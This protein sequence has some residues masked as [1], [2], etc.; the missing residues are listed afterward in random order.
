M[1]DTFTISLQQLN[2]TLGDLEDNRAVAE[3]AVRAA[4]K[5]D[6]VVFPEL[7]ITGYPPEDLVLKRAFTERAMAEVRALAKA[8]AD[9]PRDRHR[10]ALVGRDEADQ[11][12]RCPDR[13]RG[14]SFAPQGSPAEL[15]RLR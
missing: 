12:R 8:C 15:R 4:G 1:R 2:P 3:A 10:D 5:V 11:R 14:R 9:G 13:R 6:L 7:F